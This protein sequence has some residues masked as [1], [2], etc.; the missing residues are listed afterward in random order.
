MSAPIKQGDELSQRI[1]KLL[2][3]DI[4][5]AFIAI[6]SG[7]P[8]ANLGDVWVVGGAVTILII[9]PAYFFY[10]LKTRNLIHI[11]FLLLTYVVF[12]VTLANIEIGNT[13]ADARNFVDGLAVIST[14]IWVFVVT[15]IMAA[16]LATQLEER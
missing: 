14:P 12:V 11:I 8:A 9:A 10:V 1:T 13:W 6:K 5:A 4:T 15:P 7:V 16:V 2:P 3:A